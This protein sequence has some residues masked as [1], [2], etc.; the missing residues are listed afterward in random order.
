MRNPVGG[1]NFDVAALKLAYA[2][3]GNLVVNWY[4]F[5]GTGSATNQ[6]HPASKLEYLGFWRNG[7]HC[8][9]L[10]DCE[11]AKLSPISQI[12][13]I[14][15]AKLFQKPKENGEIDHECYMTTKSTS[16]LKC[17]FDKRLNT[18]VLTRLRKVE[19]LL[20]LHFLSCHSQNCLPDRQSDD[21]E[22]APKPDI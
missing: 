15:R 10:L 16:P 7:P 8:N 17:P 14:Q 20:T 11:M 12:K 5:R 13:S 21:D 4:T 22:T 9:D 1:L 3:C 6:S 2:T 18:S 19:V